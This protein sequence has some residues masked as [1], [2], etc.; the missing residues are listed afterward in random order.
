MVRTTILMLLALAAGCASFT[1]PENEIRVT[2][3][4]ADGSYLMQASG[5]VSGCRVVQAGTIHGCLKF[6]GASCA[7]QSDDC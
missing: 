4:G 5:A 1:R 3:Y 7:F 2:E 6:H